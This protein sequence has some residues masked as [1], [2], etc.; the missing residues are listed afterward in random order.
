MIDQD[1]VRRVIKQNEDYCKEHM[2]STQTEDYYKSDRDVENTW[3]SYIAQAAL[4]FMEY[5]DLLFKLEDDPELSVIL[6]KVLLHRAEF[7][8]G[9]LVKGFPRREVDG[10]ICQD[11]EVP[12][13][14]ENHSFIIRAKAVEQIGA[15]VLQK[16]LEDAEAEY[17]R[18]K[19]NY[20]LGG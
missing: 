17:D 19:T 14:L 18:K 5:K 20:S 9:G 1:T 2:T 8:G 16:M 12:A 4:T 11:D 10:F 13:R 7:T 3:L 15:D 6:R